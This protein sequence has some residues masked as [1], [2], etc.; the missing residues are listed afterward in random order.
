MR[1]LKKKKKKM[2]MMMMIRQVVKMS[3]TLRGDRHSNDIVA[4]NGQR[5]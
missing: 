1:K 2:M 3:F 5:G 4:S